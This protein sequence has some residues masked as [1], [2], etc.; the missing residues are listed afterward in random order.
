MYD[1]DFG[2][3]SRAGEVLQPLSTV[4]FKEQENSIKDSYLEYSMK[5]YARSGIKQIFG[6][7][8]LEYI[9][10]PVDYISSMMEISTEMLKTRNNALSDIESEL[11]DE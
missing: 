9:S 7:T 6:L 11:N 10:M 3:R 1:Y 2:L 4:K 8:Y 5:N